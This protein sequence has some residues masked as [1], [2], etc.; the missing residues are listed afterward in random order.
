ME[1]REGC[2]VDSL[3]CDSGRAVVA[4]RDGMDGMDSMDSVDRGTGGLGALERLA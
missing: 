4:E 3:E 1:N 2:G